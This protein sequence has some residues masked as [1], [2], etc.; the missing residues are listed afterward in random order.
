MPAGAF[1]IYREAT[2]GEG[3]DGTGLTSEHWDTIVHES[4]TNTIQQHATQ[5]NKITLKETGK[6]LVLYNLCFVGGGTNKRTEHQAII[7]HYLTVG[8]GP[9]GASGYSR[10]TGGCEEAYICGA[11]IVN[12]PTANQ[13]LSIGSANTSTESGNSV[14]RRANLCGLQVLKLDDD[15]DYARLKQGG[16]LIVTPQTMNT[17]YTSISWDTHDEFDTATFQMGSPYPSGD[18][19]VK[20]SGDYLVTWSVK[21]DILTTGSGVRKTFL[22][23]LH[24]N[25]SPQRHGFAGAYLR[26][27]NGCDHGIP[28]GIALLKLNA[29]DLI[30]LRGKTDNSSL[31]LS[32]NYLVNMQVVALPS[33]INKLMCHSNFLTQTWDTAG[34]DI[35]FDGEQADDDAFEH[36]TSTN[37]DRM[38]VKKKGH[39]L[40]CFGGHALRGSGSNR[41]DDIIRFSKNGTLQQ[42]GN[43]GEYNRGAQGGQNSYQSMC[44]HGIIFNDLEVNDIIR[45]RIIDES[46]ASGTAPV[47]GALSHG[48][49]GIHLNSIFKYYATHLVDGLLTDDGNVGGRLTR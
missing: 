43:F 7:S 9:G 17:S 6:Y 31:K 40:F 5:K 3:R 8:L 34:A 29:N 42:Y 41:Y 19:K 1:G 36:N 12:I 25:G 10:T 16:G 26:G 2:G 30:S 22:T 33:T 15:W 27:L 48:A 32:N 23:A 38:T 46:T 47:F 11:G 21:G 18:L 28:S 39:F 37:R 20:Y 35:Q 24:V 4:D 14:T 13:N 49:F 44:S 45:A